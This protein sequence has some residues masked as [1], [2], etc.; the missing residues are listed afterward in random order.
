MV[1][2]VFPDAIGPC[3]QFDQNNSRKKSPDVRPK[4]HAARFADS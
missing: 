4:R 2:A 1:L 3:E